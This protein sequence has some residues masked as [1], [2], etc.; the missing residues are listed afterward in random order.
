MRQRNRK[1]EATD[2]VFFLHLFLPSRLFQ[3][4]GDLHNL[5]EG[6]QWSQKHIYVTVASSIMEP[7]VITVPLSVPHFPVSFMPISLKLHPYPS[8]SVSTYT[9][10]SSLFSREL[11]TGT[12]GTRDDITKQTLGAGFWSWLLS[13]LKATETTSLL[14]KA[15]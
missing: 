15:W 7:L 8:L 4:A 5:S 3:D 6:G 14:V 2:K 1:E 12:I 9:F 10:F 11:K 13:D